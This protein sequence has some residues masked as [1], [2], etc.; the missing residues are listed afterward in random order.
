MRHKNRNELRK[1]PAAA[2]REQERFQNHPTS[3]ADVLNKL[4]KFET[5]GFLL[6]TRI[7]LAREQWERVAKQADFSPAKVAL[8]FCIS[9]RHLQR[10]FKQHFHCTPGRWMR[11]LRCRLAKQLLSRGLRTKTVAA[12]LKFASSSHFCREFKTF[13]GASP[14]SFALKPRKKSGKD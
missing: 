5:I 1:V 12:Q 6:M 3:G 14:Q 11:H 4:T 2:I 9:E 8:L 13:F 10:I 7:P